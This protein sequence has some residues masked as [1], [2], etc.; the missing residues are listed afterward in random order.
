MNKVI[1]GH[2]IKVKR[3]LG[4][5]RALIYANDLIELDPDDAQAFV[6]RGCIFDEMKELDKAFVDYDHAIYLDPRCTDAYI[7][8][9]MAYYDM[10][11]YEAGSA[12]ASKAILLEPGLGE[13]Y[14]S[15]AMCLAKLSRHAEAEVDLDRAFNLG[16]GNRALIQTHKPFKVLTQP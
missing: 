16:Y 4:S 11:L 2:V 10:G 5:E 6:L 12:N 8:R 3:Q 13:G 7:N 14:L 15:R 9:G 1:L